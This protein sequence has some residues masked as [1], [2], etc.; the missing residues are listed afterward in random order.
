MKKLFKNKLITTFL[1]TLCLV[2]SGMIFNNASAEYA[3]CLEMHKVMVK[4]LDY[5]NV[6]HTSCQAAHGYCVVSIVPTYNVTKCSNCGYEF[7]RVKSGVQVF[8]SALGETP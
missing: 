7:K 5:G 2:G 6:Q 8:H 3:C 1:L 4:E